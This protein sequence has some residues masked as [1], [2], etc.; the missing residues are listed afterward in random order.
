MEAPQR[1]TPT[2]PGINEVEGKSLPGNEL[3]GNALAELQV[4]QVAKNEFM[5]DVVVELQRGHGHGQV[6]QSAELDAGEAQQSLVPVA[7]PYR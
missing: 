6:P 3:G 7:S 5:G 2:T 1:N 4:L